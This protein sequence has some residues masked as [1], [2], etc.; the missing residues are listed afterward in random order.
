MRRT[1]IAVVLLAAFA[2]FVWLT[3]LKPAGVAEED[4]SVET[5]VAVHVGQI[6]RTTLRG[7]VTAY[8]V[9]EPAP[10]GE[11][12]AASARIAPSV[13][14]V[15]SA[16]RCAE[17][18]HVERGTLLFQ[19]DSRVADV[20]AEKARHA[21]EFAEAN[22]TR[23]SKLIKVEGTSQKLLLEAEQALAA[24]RSELAAAETQQELLRVKAPLSG[25][26]TRVNVKAGEAVDLTTTLADIVDLDRLVV[27]A[28]VPSA[29]LA[30]LG[31][32]QL[33]EV[34]VDRSLPPTIGSLTYLSPQVDLRTGTAVARVSLPAGSGLRPG[35]FVTLRIVS[36]ERK[37]RLAVPIESVAKGSDG[38]SVIALVQGDKAVQKAVKTGLREGGLIEIEADGLQA[39]MEVVT[40]G[41]YALPRETKI[42]VLGE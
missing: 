13:A 42:R 40:K 1:L 18:Q 4:A 36:D 24:A 41:S 33:A 34:I 8:G 20:A 7:Y 22:A 29:E 15:I 5:E 6:T 38:G 17:G 32:G 19:L 37:D 28:S 35:Q 14:G 10:P 31:L 16:V 23:L 2:G 39:G 30:P 26:V 9:V 21:V 27:N 11:R 12:A 25:T 3:W